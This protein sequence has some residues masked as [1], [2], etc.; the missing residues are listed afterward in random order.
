MKMAML[1]AAAAMLCGAVV[2]TRI[3]QAADVIEIKVLGTPGVREFY[4]ELVPQFEKAT[5]HKVA[6]VWGG[7]VDVVK[8]VGG[9]ESVDLVIMSRDALEELIRLGKIV[10]DSRVDVAKSGVGVA[11]RAGAPKPDISSGEAVKKA[12]LAAKSIAY[13]SGPSGVYM[14]GLIQRMGIADEVKSKIKQIPPGEAVGDLIARGEA[15]IGFHQVS[16]LL[17]VKGIDIV[18]PLPPDIQQITVFSAGLHVGAKEADAAKA[19]IAFLTT[20]AAATVIKKH[21]MDPG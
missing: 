4:A 10:P 19:L 14:A 15:E 18:G 16:E 7:N 17:P 5:G 1:A 8:R 13:S 2:A 6:T 21:G 9:G 20:P 12:L 11:V 3:A